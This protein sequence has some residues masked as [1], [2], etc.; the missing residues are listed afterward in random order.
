MESH[1]FSGI[2]ARLWRYQ[3]LGYIGI[4][5]LGIYVTGYDSSSEMIIYYP[6]QSSTHLY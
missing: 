6:L 3:Q 2:M 5:T 1:A 4:L